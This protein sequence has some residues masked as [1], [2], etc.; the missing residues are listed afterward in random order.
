MRPQGPGCRADGA[1]GWD[2]TSGPWLRRPILYPLSYGRTTCP[3]SNSASQP[4]PFIIF[5]LWQDFLLNNHTTCVPEDPMSEAPNSH[6]SG[7]EGPIQTPKQLAVA[8]ALAF[9]VPIAIIVL[10]VVFVSSAPK[11]A[12]GSDALT[13][14]ATAERIMPIGSVE[15]KAAVTRTGPASGE[16][17]YKTQCAACHTAGTLGAPKFGDAGSWAARL[18]AGLA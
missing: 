5:P 6:D 11:G 3:H 1:P 9:I 4:S 15:I 17:V 8:V 12:A 7:H 2:R 16:E 14:Q 10:L 18:G 13:A